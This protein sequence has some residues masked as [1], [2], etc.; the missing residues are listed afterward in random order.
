MT[1]AIAS[2]EQEQRILHTDIALEQLEEIMLPL[3][4]D[5]F[6]QNVEATVYQLIW[7]SKHGSAI[8]QV[9]KLMLSIPRRSIRT[10][11]TSREPRKRRLFGEQDQELGNP[12]YMIT[13]LLDLWGA[14][15]PVRLERSVKDWMQKE[16]KLVSSLKF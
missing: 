16:K 7:K 3:A 13:H 6:S 1:M 12:T 8:I 11:R 4:I 15:V 5:Y 9:E 2:G 14:H 10:R